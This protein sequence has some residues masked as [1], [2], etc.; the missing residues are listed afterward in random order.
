MHLIPIVPIEPGR[1]IL[2]PHLVLAGQEDELANQPA[3]DVLLTVQHLIDGVAVIAL[4]GEQTPLIG[5]FVQM[6]VLDEKD[7]LMFADQLL[8]HLLAGIAASG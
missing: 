2:H 4:V 6:A 5:Q 3:F 1:I 7:I 8:P